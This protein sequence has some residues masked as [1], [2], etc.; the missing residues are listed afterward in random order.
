MC[1]RNNKEMELSGYTVLPL[2]GAYKLHADFFPRGGRPQIIHR[3]LETDG[4]SKSSSR[5][6]ALK[7]DSSLVKSL[8]GI[9]YADETQQPCE[10][11]VSILFVHPTGQSV[12]V[13]AYSSQSPDVINF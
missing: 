3:E 1:T 2:A 8:D 6:P 13:L 5:I 12:F 7:P 11:V 4:Y 10:Q 9:K